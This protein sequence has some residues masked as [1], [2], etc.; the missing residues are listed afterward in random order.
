M[1]ETLGSLNTSVAGLRPPI[2]QVGAADRARAGD[3]A[4]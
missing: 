4:R 2:R 3:A 1:F